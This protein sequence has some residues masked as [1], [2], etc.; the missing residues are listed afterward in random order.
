V[1]AS[2]TKELDNNPS[3]RTPR[4]FQYAPKS[5]TNPTYMTDTELQEKMYRELLSY[6]ANSTA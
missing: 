1:F 5:K 4:N 2:L 3:H 6:T